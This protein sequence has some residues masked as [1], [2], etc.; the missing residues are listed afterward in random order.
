PTILPPSQTTPPPLATS[1]TILPAAG[2]PASPTE[3]T[4]PPVGLTPLSPTASD[5]PSQPSA[6]PSHQWTPIA[7]PTVLPPP[8]VEE[9]VHLPAPPTAGVIAEPESG[10]SHRAR[11][12]GEL[13]P[14]PDVITAPQMIGLPST[15]GKFP[16]FMIVLLRFVVAALMG[17]RAVQDA[18]HLSATTAIWQNT[19]LPSP[20]IFAWAQ[21]CVEAA[22][23]LLLVFGIGVR[24]VGALLV[25]LNIG[26]LAF[27]YWGAVSPFQDG[28][29]GFTGELQVLLIGVGLLWIGVGGGGWLS[30]DSFIHRDR[31]RRRNERS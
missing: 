1:P 17:I 20:Q 7:P 26:L 10:L 30:V 3:P 16:S 9:T 11:A 18:S 13:A 2:F 21:I 8:A 28:V 19:V 23:A 12:L 14:T 4:L 5:Q 27:V 29:S 6:P 15:Y 22:C 25:L 31:V 24:L